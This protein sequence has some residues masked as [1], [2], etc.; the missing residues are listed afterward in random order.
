MA[1]SRARP[2][3]TRG[4]AIAAQ[5]LALL[6]VAVGLFTIVVGV[7]PRTVPDIVYHLAIAAVLAWGLITAIR[8]PAGSPAPT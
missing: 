5:A 3:W 4:A 7:G 1:L 8:R 2:D 6:G